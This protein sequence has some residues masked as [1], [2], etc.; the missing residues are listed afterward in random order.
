MN[1]YRCR[2]WA[3]VTDREIVE[4][5]VTDSVEHARER[6]RSMHGVWPTSTRKLK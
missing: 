1:L 6:F 4:D 2:G 5:V 3:D